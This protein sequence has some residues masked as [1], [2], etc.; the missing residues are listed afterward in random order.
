MSRIYYQ[1]HP[2]RTVLYRVLFHYFE[3]FLHEYENRFEKHYGYLRSIIKEVADKYLECGN[4]MNGF[5]RLKCSY[6]GREKLLMFSCKVRGF[7]PSCHAKRRE[8]WGEWVNFHPHLHFLV[9]EGGTDKQGQ[10]HKFSNF[11]DTLLCR[12]FTREVFSLFLRKQL[13]NRDFIKK[14][15]SWRHTG[16]NVHSKVRAESKEEAE[17]IGKYMIRPVLSLRRLSLDEAK[18]QVLY[19]YGKNSTESECM[20]YLEFIARVTSHIPEKGQ[21][22]IRYY[23]LYSNAHRGK[24]RKTGVCPPVIK[25]EVSFTPSRGWAEMIKKVYEIDPLICPK[26]GGTMRIIS[27]IKDHKVIDKIIDHLK[28]TFKAE[29]PPPAQ[30]QLSM[31]A[32]ERSE[33]I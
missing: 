29:R 3:R 9:T 32:E 1:R 7:C 12:F 2:E 22:M 10:F 16:F 28:L 8:E 18:G 33:Y 14:I 13:I 26:C 31:A 30:A 15:L 4:P 27:F 20:D 6:C 11:N 19:Q 25:D 24:K 23:G 17:R 5:A 21:V